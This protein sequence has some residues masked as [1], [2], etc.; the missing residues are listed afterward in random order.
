MFFLFVPIYL[1]EALGKD[2]SSSSP[3]TTW[4]NFTITSVCVIIAA[5]PASYLAE[6]K[7]LG[8]RYTLLVSSLATFAFYIA[9]VKVETATQNLAYSCVISFTIAVYIN[10]IYAY[11]VEAS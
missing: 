4:R 10:V 6:T 1:Q 9:Y 2:F 8:R 11:T 7:L 3:Y 5:F